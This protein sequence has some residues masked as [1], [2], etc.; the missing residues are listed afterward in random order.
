MG[1]ADWDEAID[2]DSEAEGLKEAKVV[3]P[4]DLNPKTRVQEANHGAPSAFFWSE[5]RMDETPVR[6]TRQRAS[7]E[8][9]GVRATRGTA[10]AAARKEASGSSGGQRRGACVPLQ[11]VQSFGI[12]FL[13]LFING[14]VRGVLENRQLGVADL[15]LQ[16]WREAQGSYQI[17]AAE[18]D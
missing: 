8:N 11:K 4:A 5:P 17:V 15:V 7:V 14:R 18:G 16:G 9:P 12:E 13:N 1:A 10:G 6:A 3:A 2:A